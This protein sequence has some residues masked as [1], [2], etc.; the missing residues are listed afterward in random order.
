MATAKG[1]NRDR[2]QSTDIIPDDNTPCLICKKSKYK[3]SIQCD[4]CEN[5]V[6]VSNAPN[7]PEYFLMK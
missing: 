5:W 4:M 3:E 7:Y 6:H 1:T 2:S